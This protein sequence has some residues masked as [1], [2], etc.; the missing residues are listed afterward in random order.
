MSKR[1]RKIVTILAAALVVGCEAPPEP[2]RVGMLVWP[3]YELAHLAQHRGYFETDRV[4]LVDFRTPAEMVRS[5]RYGIID[6]MYVTSQFALT[7]ADSL[8]DSRIVHLID[9]SYGGD[10]LLA[11]TGIRDA[12]ELEGKRVGM[13][14][15]PLGAYTMIRALEDHGLAREDVEIVFVDT[16]YQLDAFRA[17]RIDALATYEPTRTQL[18]ELGAHELFNSRAIPLE[19]IDVL[20]ARDEVIETKAVMLAELVRGVDRALAD[21]RS[22]PDESVALMASRQGISPTAFEEAMDGVRLL[23][24]EDNLALLSGNDERLKRGL[25]RQC[26]VML[27]A[28]MIESAPDIERLI[29]IRI[30]EMADE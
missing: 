15:G 10:A 9:F 19:I 13:E 23:N 16:P 6:A 11:S 3:P 20:L 4:E 27:Q 18:L 14:A 1:L 25:V 17:G 12:S 21:Y 5:Y 2:V 26:D 22:S 24:L 7:N 30:V 29:D 8:A 28:G